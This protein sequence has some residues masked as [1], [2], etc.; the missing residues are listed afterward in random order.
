MLYK[1]LEYRK[2]WK[3]ASEI[4]WPLKSWEFSSFREKEDLTVTLVSG[5]ALFSSSF[6]D[7]VSDSLVAEQFFAGTI[8]TKDVPFRNHTFVTPPYSTNCTFVGHQTYVDIGENFTTEFFRYDQNYW[9]F[10]DSLPLILLLT[11]GLIAMK[12]TLFGVVW[13]LRLLFC[14]GY[15]FGLWLPIIWEKRIYVYPFLIYVYLFS[16]FP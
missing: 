2:P 4:I 10:G 7:V 12:M 13:W 16:Y 3:I 11:L 9:N 6:Y 5:V 14:Q 1:N 15:S 8:Y